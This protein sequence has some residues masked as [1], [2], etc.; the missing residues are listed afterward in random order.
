MGLSKFC[1]IHCI[2]Y[3]SKIRFGILLSLVS[4]SSSYKHK[5]SILS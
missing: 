4:R 5:M 3:L 1:F 2:E